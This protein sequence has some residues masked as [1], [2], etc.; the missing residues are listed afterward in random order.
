MKHRSENRLRRLETSYYGDPV[1]AATTT[2]TSQSRGKFKCRPGILPPK[3]FV[4]YQDILTCGSVRLKA[5]AWLATTLLTI[6]AYHRMSFKVLLWTHTSLR[7]RRTVLSE[8]YNAARNSNPR[9]AEGSNRFLFS[10]NFLSLLKG[11]TVGG[12]IFNH[13]AINSTIA[14]AAEARGQG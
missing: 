1:A 7:T 12:Y 13:L 3:N 14:L 8:N 10:L 11:S 4:Y 5:G 9:L 2:S 6:W